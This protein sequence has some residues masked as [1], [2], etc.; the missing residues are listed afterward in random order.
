[1]FSAEDVKFHDDGDQGSIPQEVKP[2]NGD[3]NGAP[4][5]TPE[6]AKLQQ[7]DATKGRWLYRKGGK[8]FATNFLKTF[9][10]QFF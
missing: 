8:A 6:V 5:K 7:H 9:S 3:K 2:A 4:A 1:M 10:L